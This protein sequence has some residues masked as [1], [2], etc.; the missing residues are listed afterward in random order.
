M[1][2]RWRWDD[3]FYIWLPFWNP[4]HN[5]S[6]Q[7]FKINPS[8]ETWR[9]WWKDALVELVEHTRGVVLNWEEKELL[10]QKISTVIEEVTPEGAT[11]HAAG[12]GV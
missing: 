10:Q 12:V 1:Q 3:P 9:G 8:S 6:T 4:E 7:R 11:D 5:G 2:V